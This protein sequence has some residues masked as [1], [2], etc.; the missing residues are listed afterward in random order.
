MGVFKNETACA[1]GPPEVLTSSFD[2]CRPNEENASRAAGE[3]SASL[4]VNAHT[5]L[6]SSTTRQTKLP[7]S[8][9]RVHLIGRMA[10]GEGRGGEGR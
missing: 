7:L 2:T 6:I 4:K 5:L 3:G 10:G 1:C 9:P 8:L